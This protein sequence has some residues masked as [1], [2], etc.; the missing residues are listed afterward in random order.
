MMRAARILVIEDLPRWQEALAE[1]FS[2][3]GFEVEV[4]ATKAEA[5]KKLAEEL[6]HLLVVD[7]RLEETDPTNEEGMDLLQELTRYGVTESFQV[8]VLTAYGTKDL[9]REAFKRHGVG[10][11]WD[12]QQFDEDEGAF[13]ADVKRLLGEGSEINLDLSVHW[14]SGLDP[15]QAVFN[16]LVDG[17]RVKRSTQEQERLAVELDDLLCRLFHDAESVVISP[18]STGKSGA[19]VLLIQPFYSHGGGRSAVVKF[20]D[21]R[22]ISDEQAKFKKFVRP[23]VGGGRSTTVIASRRTP[24]L[25]GIVYSLVGDSGG[26]LANFE[27][28]YRSSSGPQICE[29]LDRLFLDTCGAWYESP[30]KLKPLDLTA[31]YCEWLGLTPQSLEWALDGLKSVQGKEKL[32][33]QTLSASVRRPFPNP[34]QFFPG[35][36]IVLPTYEII[37]HGDLNPQ[38]VLLDDAGQSWLIDFQAT[39]P[40]HVLRDVAEMDVAIRIQ[41]L[42][43]SEA[44]LDER[45]ALEEALCR[46][47]SYAQLAELAADSSNPAVEKARAICVHLRTLAGRLLARHTSSDLTEYYVATLFCALPMMRFSFLGTVQREHALLSACLLTERHGF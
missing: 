19:G 29:A 11:F 37:T 33:F 2:S 16:L 39:G 30:G 6:F 23:F 22:Q 17:K 42:G 24:R 15:K 31:H 25:G 27:G 7:L 32:H 4:A 35:T 45:L 26:Q 38:N 10:D 46:P 34:L 28:F 12:K 36:P 40:G 20:G 44:T 5:S 21:V 43:P 47:E 3:S 18:L 8:I 14:Q 41:L 13:L 9:M 1:T